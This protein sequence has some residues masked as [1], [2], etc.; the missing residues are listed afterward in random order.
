MF[1]DQKQKNKTKKKKNKQKNH[2]LKNRQPC[3]NWYANLKKK[4]KKF[5]IFKFPTWIKFIY[6]NLNLSKVQHSNRFFFQTKAYS[7]CLFNSLTFEIKN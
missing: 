7:H 1:L 4:K 3:F 6:I 2:L 5:Q